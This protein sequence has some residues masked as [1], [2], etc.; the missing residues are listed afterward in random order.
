VVLCRWC[1]PTGLVG[2]TLAG[3]ITEADRHELASFVTDAI[4]RFGEVRVLIGVERYVGRLHDARFDPDALWNERDA[5]GISRVAVVGEPAWKVIAPAASRH[6][7][8][9]IEYFA[10]EY[11]AR[12]WLTGGRMP[13][14][15][16]RPSRAHVTSSRLR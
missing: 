15:A 10:N 3:A 7:R 8:V 6:R 14:A 16:E 9:P 12:C 4:A 11:A 5:A 13:D 2:A 1:E